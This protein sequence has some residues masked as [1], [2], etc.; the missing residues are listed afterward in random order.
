MTLTGIETY[1]I[2]VKG[3]PY[4]DALYFVEQVKEG[5]SIADYLTEKEIEECEAYS[6]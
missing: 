6:K 2:D 5:D 3:Y 1:M 4:E